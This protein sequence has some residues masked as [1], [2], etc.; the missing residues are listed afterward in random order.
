MHL[1]VTIVFQLQLY[2]RVGA[3]LSEQLPAWVM[4]GDACLIVVLIFFPPA[5]IGSEFTPELSAEALRDSVVPVTAGA[6]YSQLPIAI[7]CG[8]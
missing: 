4:F 1:Q 6:N 7:T 3:H 5:I 2:Q 8:R